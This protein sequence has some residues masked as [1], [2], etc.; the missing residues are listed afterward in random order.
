MMKELKLDIEL[1]A[2]M[3]AIVL[4]RHNVTT[5]KE[6]C[7]LTDEEMAA[8]ANSYNVELSSEFCV[9]EDAVHQGMR[10]FKKG[11]LA[12]GFKTD[13]LYHTTKG[14]QAMSEFGGLRSYDI[15]WKVKFERTIEGISMKPRRERIIK[16]RDYLIGFSL[17][18]K[19]SYNDIG[20]MIHE[21]SVAAPDESFQSPPQ[22][23]KHRTKFS[24]LGKRQIDDIVDDVIN[25]VIRLMVWIQLC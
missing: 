25:K 14:Q 18:D 1:S 4:E 16:R 9:L 8:E 21:M 7:Y 12:N 24:D 3:L 2:Y 13:I 19:S 15:G 10:P 22:N 17:Y 23:V 5:E 20:V 11:L 6:I